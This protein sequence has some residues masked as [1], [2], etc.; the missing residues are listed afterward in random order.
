MHDDFI[1]VSFNISPTNQEN[2]NSD[3][4]NF[5]DED[6]YL[7]L[8]H[9]FGRNLEDSVS[10]DSTNEKEESMQSSNSKLDSYLD[11]VFSLIIRDFVMS[12][13]SEF[14]WEKEK[15]SVLAKFVFL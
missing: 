6:E 10:I 8:S 11:E 1:H 9:E 14:I 3:E 13:M 5:E 4:I 7:D 2:I 12:W 15:F